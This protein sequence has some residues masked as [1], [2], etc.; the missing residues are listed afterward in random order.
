M[1]VPRPNSPARSTTCASWR[2][3]IKT[4]SGC[5]EAEHARER[6]E[7]VAREQVAL[8]GRIER[9]AVERDQAGAELAAAVKQMDIAF[10]KLIK[11]PPELRWFWSVMVTPATPGLTNGHAASREDAMAKFCAAWDQHEKT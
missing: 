6:A 2:A 3:G 10:R 9:K 1:T 5:F 7:R 8:I 11:L 4:S